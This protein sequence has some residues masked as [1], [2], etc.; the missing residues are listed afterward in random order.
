M[1]EGE[2]NRGRGKEEQ[3][4]RREGKEERGKEGK[5]GREGWRGEERR[6]LKES[7]R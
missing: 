6:G 3:V 1:E 7:R 5:R 4:S 2:E